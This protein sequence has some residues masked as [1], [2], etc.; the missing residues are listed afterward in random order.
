MTIN[1]SQYDHTK[2]YEYYRFCQ[3]FN[4]GHS[5]SQLTGR[6]NLNFVPFFHLLANLNAMIHT[7]VM[8]HDIFWS[9]RP[10]VILFIHS[11]YPSTS[12]CNTHSFLKAAH[13]NLDQLQPTQ[14]LSTESL[15][16]YCSPV[17]QRHTV[18]LPFQIK[19]HFHR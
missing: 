18:S 9:Y 3:Y 11:F 10:P 14:I 7:R 4:T 12:A 17:G 1:L 15:M 13:S 5:Y 2:H 16:T 6:L 8:S 19:E